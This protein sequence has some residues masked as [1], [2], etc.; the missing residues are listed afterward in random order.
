MALHT[1]NPGDTKRQMNLAPF[2]EWSATQQYNV[3]DLVV[4]S[5]GVWKAKVNNR[6]Q[7][8]DENTFWT[9]VAGG[10]GGGITGAC[11]EISS[12]TDNS[13]TICGS[14]AGDPTTIV[15]SGVDTNQVL[16]IYADGPDAVLWHKYDWGNSVKGAGFIQ[17]PTLTAGMQASTGI[18]P[19][20]GPFVIAHNDFATAISVASAGTGVSPGV[21][22]LNSRGSIASPSQTQGNDTVGTVQFNGRSTDEYIGLA[23][24]K[25]LPTANVVTSGTP[26]VMDLEVKANTGSFITAIRLTPLTVILDNL[27]STNPGISGGLY[28]TTTARLI[29]VSSG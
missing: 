10:G 2:M 22:L 21:Y 11:I 1:T 4:S 23:R 19:N 27:P 20:F 9:K 8:P 29:A 12:T 16:Q 17:T 26:T 25:V 28:M 7:N 13:I 5:S 6:A 24:I 14:T 3:D 15:S 18:L